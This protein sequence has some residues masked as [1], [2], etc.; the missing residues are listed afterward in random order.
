VKIIASK[1]L[2]DCLDGTS[3]MEYRLDSSITVA[4]IHYMGTFGKLD[5]FENMERPFF[6]VKKKG[7]YIFK[8][9]LTNDSVQV[10]Y[11]EDAASNERIRREEIMAFA[12]E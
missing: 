5:F 7:A 8:G 10:L 9:I 6:R 4:F 12:D 2:E 1:K 3:L 11:L